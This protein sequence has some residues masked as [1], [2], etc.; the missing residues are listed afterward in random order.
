MRVGVSA[1]AALIAAAVWPIF[2]LS[3]EADREV[4]L[5]AIDKTFYVEGQSTPNPTLKLRAGERVRLVVRNQDEGM[6]HDLKI[7]EWNIAVPPIN[8]KGE[9]AVTFRVPES[10]RGASYACTPHAASMFGSIEVE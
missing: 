3:R 5:V 7:R 10:R 9:S 4:R 6:R 2:G 8:G 1:A